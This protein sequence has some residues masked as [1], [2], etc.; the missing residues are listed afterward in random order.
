[1]RKTKQTFRYVRVDSLPGETTLKL[2]APW[3]HDRGTLPA[4]T[5]VRPFCAGYD[6]LLD[7]DYRTVTVIATDEE[8]TGPF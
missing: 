6:S 2:T 3:R 7:R 5:L 4:G 1:M 8:C